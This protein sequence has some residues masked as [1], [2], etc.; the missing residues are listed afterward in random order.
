M[1][2]LA[3]SAARLWYVPGAGQPWLTGTTLQLTARSHHCL[4]WALCRCAQTLGAGQNLQDKELIACWSSQGAPCPTTHLLGLLAHLLPLPSLLRTREFSSPS[5]ALSSPLALAPASLEEA[6]GRQRDESQDI[7]HSPRQDLEPHIS[8]HWNIRV[9]PPSSCARSSRRRLG[10]R[11]WVWRGSRV[12]WGCAGSELLQWEH[13]LGGLFRPACPGPCTSLGKRH[14]RQAAQEPR[15][16]RAARARAAPMATPRTG[17]STRA[18]SRPAPAVQTPQHPST[19][20][21]HHAHPST[22]TCGQ[23]GGI[24]DT[25]TIGCTDREVSCCAAEVD[26]E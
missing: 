23:E 15:L 24:G 12:P 13:W 3:P 19:G 9:L 14:T 16:S 25:H 26:V 22:V 10:G 2:F 20:P 5:R 6:A 11:D 8:L 7:Y 4:C 18:S 21:L 1:A 17:S